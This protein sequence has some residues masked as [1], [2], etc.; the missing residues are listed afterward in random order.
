MP[1][2]L[3]NETQQRI[4]VSQQSL[5]LAFSLL[6]DPKAVGYEHQPTDGALEMS[7]IGIAADLAIAACLYEIYGYSGIIRDDTSFYLTASEALH[8][9]RGALV[10]AIP[11]LEAITSGIKDPAQ[12]LVKLGEACSGF[13]VIFTARASA[14]HGGAGAS[15]DVAFFAGKSV[16]DFLSLLAQSPKWKPYLKD[17]PYVPKLPKD[18]RL[19]AQELAAALSSK[20]KAKVTTALSG[21]FLVLP[22]LS[23]KEPDWLSALQHIQVTPRSQDITILI[24]SLKTAQVGD[25]FKVGKGSSALPAK[26]DPSNPLALP[27]YPEA[28]KKKFENLNDQWAGYVATANAE[29]DKGILSVPP[30]EAIYRF[31]AVGIDKIGLPEDELTNGMSAHSVWP[32]VA[33]ALNYP[34]T[35]GP[36]FFVVRAIKSSEIGQLTALLKKAGV[37]GNKVGKALKNYEALII[38]AARQEAVKSPS[39]LAGV[40]SEAVRIREAKRQQLTDTMRDRATHANGTTKKI[41]QKLIEAVDKSDWLAQIIMQV[42]TGKMNFDAEKL[43]VMRLLVEAATDREDLEALT[44]IEMHPELKI[45]TQARKAIMEIDYAFFGPQR[46]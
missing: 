18:R 37:L 20:D 7:L 4:V 21:L 14:L 46:Q 32:F 2:L 13:S 5:R 31:A 1:R 43:P 11:R 27:I 30:V 6:S 36:C 44:Y 22:E 34:G 24:K 17:I 29:L 19:L 40:L 10:S 41:Y 3:K 25:I 33:G 35:K 8:K 9:F 28:M 16:A 23:S 15:H 38:A 39:A 42:A 26:I 45:E 12:H